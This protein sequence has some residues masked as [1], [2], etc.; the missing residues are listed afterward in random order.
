MLSYQSS[1]HSLCF[2]VVLISEAEGHCTFKTLFEVV[3][4]P[5]F[6]QVA[7][8]ANGAEV[9]LYGGLIRFGHL[10]QLGKS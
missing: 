9:H 5:N 6:T 3:H 1:P 2:A 7:A 10:R 4:Y 8:Y